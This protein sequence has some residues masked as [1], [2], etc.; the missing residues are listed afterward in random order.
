MG[1]RARFTKQ[2][3]YLLTPEMAERVATIAEAD[4]DGDSKSSAAR[5]LI[6]LGLKRYD[7]LKAEDDSAT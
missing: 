1:K 3:V 4:M 7:A 6:G 5:L 2:E